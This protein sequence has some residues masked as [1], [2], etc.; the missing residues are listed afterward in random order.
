[1]AET[2]VLVDRAG[3]VT[4]V[5]D[6]HVVRRDNLLH[7]A[8]AVLVRNGAGAIYLHR[9]A[10]DK[11]WAPGFYDCAAGGLLRPDEGPEA[12]ALR[13]LAEEL[14]VTEVA[15][16][17]LGTSLYEDERVRCFEHCFEVTWE[18]PVAHV[19]AEV[20]WG[21]WVTLDE[22]DRLLADG[23]RPFVPDTKQLLARL[24]NTDVGDYARLA[25]LRGRHD[26]T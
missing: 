2:V 24:A 16:R 11:D 19:D 15:L 12:S 4:G 22:L 6:R 9:R 17:P 5:A 21:A 7:A 8:T 1:M 25:A 23:D 20:E 18:G 10:A 13:E 26:G 3:R 14:G